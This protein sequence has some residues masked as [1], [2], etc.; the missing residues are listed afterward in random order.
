MKKAM[1]PESAAASMAGN[2]RAEAVR[3]SAGRAIAVEV[4]DSMSLLKRAIA[5]FTCRRARA[6][7]ETSP[8][9]RRVSAE[10]DRENAPPPSATHCL[11]S[12]MTGIY[13]CDIHDRD[14]G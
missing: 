11:Y 10:C 13:G 8:P 5:R 4:D 1:R 6:G 14:P 3:I 12:R 7:T 2:L 9:I